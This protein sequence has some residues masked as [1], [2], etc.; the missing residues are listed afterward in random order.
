[1][2]TRINLSIPGEL[3]ERM[4]Q[5]TDL[6]WSKVAQDAF[7][8]QIEIYELKA[9][10]MNQEA[11]LVRLRASKKTN[12]EREEAEGTAAGKLWALEVAEYDELAK[13]AALNDNYRP[14]PGARELAEAVGRD[15]PDWSE[16]AEEMEGLF[17]CKDPSESLIQ[18]FIDGAIEVFN[19]I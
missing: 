8:T 17:G 2:A 9:K 3:K 12:A 11:G 16:A 1:M 19:D 18:G 15:C 10:D 4:D 13:V 6:N 5:L 7:E 14:T